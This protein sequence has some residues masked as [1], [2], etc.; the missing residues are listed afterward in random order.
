MTAVR[1]SVAAAGY[2][3]SQALQGKGAVLGRLRRLEASQWWPPERIQAAQAARLSRL[4][5]HCY[6]HV[7]YYRE[8]MDGAG[9]D[10]RDVVDQASFS[11]LPVLTRETLRTRGPDLVARTADRAHLPARWSSG[12]TGERVEVRQD[13]QF[14]QWCRAHQ[15]RTY[16]WCG[17]WRLGEPF[18]LVWGSP[19][20]FEARSRAQDL[21]NRISRR[22]EL[23]AFRLDRPSVDRTL[24]ALARVQPHLVSGY[25]TAL[26]V[27]GQRARARGVELPHLRAV[28]PT[29]EPMTP[30]MRAGIE[31][32]FGCPAFDKYGSRESSI[33]A[34]ESPAHAGLCV[35][36]EHTYLEFLGPGGEPCPPGRP[37]RI[38]L[39]TL[40]NDAQPLLRYETSDVAAPLDGR[41]PSGIGLPLMTPVEGRLQDVL[42]TPDGGI[43]HP[44]LFSNVIRQLPAVQWFQV[45]QEEE[46][47]L[48][49][50]LV[51]PAGRLAA[52]D[53]ERIA[54]LI[55]HHAGFD[56]AIDFDHLAD[57]PDPST[58]TGKFR[59]CVCAVPAGAQVL[60]SLHAARRAEP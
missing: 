58:A 32:G 18:A 53:Q 29:A 2:W 15:L 59:L 5:A 40:H 57:M 44:Q 51:A 30:A 16:R 20:Q 23:N 14:D 1:R 34:H 54:A 33:A 45:V 37:G 9:I 24:D 7:P 17:G 19:V 60:A 50:R 28:Q 11:Q 46:A 47:R 31:E 35:Q 4:V 10:P 42:C 12:S 38:V 13:R 36:A 25:T 43:V 3:T 48:T 39:T 49:V 22:V 52:E 41:C 26:F 8:V 6:E 27:L 21:D 56:Y 55:R